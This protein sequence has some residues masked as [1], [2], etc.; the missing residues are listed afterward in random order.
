LYLDTSATH[1]IILWPLV[2]YFA[3]VIL[4]VAGMLALSY[5]LGQRH[6][7]KATGEPYES[8]IVSTGSARLRFP[9]QFYLVAMLFVIFD[10]E[11]V[12]IFAWAVAFRELGWGGYIGV[13][14]FI[15]VLV[16]ALVYAWRVGILDWGSK[17][18]NAR[19]TARRRADLHHY[20]QEYEGRENNSYL[21]APSFH[22]GKTM[23]RNS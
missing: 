10:L 7:A 2:V 16:A 14:V 23:N 22:V 17:G 8:G 11:A 19:L 12:F 3:A 1:D 9:A 4:L 5:L 13:L 6:Q 21:P 18:R 15:G 20:E